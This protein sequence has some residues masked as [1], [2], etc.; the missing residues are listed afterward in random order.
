MCFS[1]VKNVKENKAHFEKCS[2]ELDTVLV[3]NSQMSK[4]KVAEVEEVQNLLVATRSLFVHETLNYVN[5]ITVLQSKKRHMVLSTV[6]NL[7][8]SLSNVI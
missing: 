2:T 3:R 1:D 7:K 5:S 8:S 4:S 6:S